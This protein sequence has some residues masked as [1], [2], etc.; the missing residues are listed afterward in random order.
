MSLDNLFQWS[1][2]IAL[3]TVAG[4]LVMRLVRIDVPTLRHAFWRI[5]LAAG[6]VL[7]IVQPW[8][9]PAAV[10]DVGPASVAMPAASVP[11]VTGAPAA[12]PSRI[13]RL[14]RG[15]ANHWLA[16]IGFVLAA[17]VAARFVWLAA[18]ILRLHRLCKSGVAAPAGSE[19]D[20]L[21]AQ[22]RA[23]AEVRYVP[24]IGQPVTFGLFR[25]VVLV[26]D[27]FATLDPAL[28]RVVLAHEL[29]HVRRRD[30]GWVLVEES[31]RAV[32][33]FNPAVS[34]IVSKVQTTREEVVD[35]LTV[36]CTSTRKAYLEA[37]LVFADQPTLFPATPLARRRHLFQRMLLISREAVMSSRRVVSSFAAA[38]VMVVASGWYSVVAFPLTAPAAGPLQAAPP[39]G[40]SRAAAAVTPRPNSTAYFVQVQAPARDRRPGEPA[41]E[42]TRERDL[43]AQIQTYPTYPELYYQL[44]G[45]Q[46]ARGDQREVDAT[47]AAL[48]RAFPGDARVLAFVARTASNSG[49]FDEAV[50][51]LSEMAAIDP[52]NP[53]SHHLIATFYWEKAYKDLSLTPAQRLEYVQSGIAATDKALGIDPDFVDALV[54]KNIL[55]RMAANLDSA[56]RDSLIAQAD[57]LRNRAGDLQR[58]RGGVSG[59][60]AGGV[61]GG[62]PGGV[63][64][65]EGGV[66]GGVVRRE[67]EFVPAPGQGAPP[68][69][70]PP[71][72]PTEMATIAYPQSVPIPEFVDGVRPV[73]VGGGIKPPVKVRDVKPFYP[74]IAQSARIQ[75]VVI[76]QAVIDTAGNVASAT[77]LRGQPLLDEAAL[78]AVGQWQFQPTVLNNVPTP[79]VMTVTVN[80]AMQ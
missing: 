31:I 21:I 19:Y 14:A 9:T 18:G 56:N 27:W 60:V 73:R 64:R 52:G 12:P 34:W 79:V 8:S 48:R 1:A 6:L 26:P 43:K 17:G 39:A 3:V 2:Q 16:W 55:L 61:S 32:L 74:P 33:W 24:R 11:V 45:L 46:Q 47:V 70:P 72:P 57:V 62:V 78:Q 36:Q 4:A 29:W 63:V 71:P 59:G 40:A 23:R 28:R 76:I 68:P 67:M 58:A 44:I 51:A 53:R 20:D 66:P 15:L 69:P 65:R 50:S 10:T 30:W 35:E 37:L 13:A 75:G 49:R 42:T 77:V 80:F 38:S 22:I 41:P 7:P 25:P 54:Y 5:L